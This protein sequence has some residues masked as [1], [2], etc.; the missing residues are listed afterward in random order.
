LV[1]AATATAGGVAAAG[2]ATAGAASRP[3]ER[4]IE[5]GRLVVARAF[6][7]ASNGHIQSIAHRG[8]TI[9]VL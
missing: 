3:I 2:T 8:R 5:A 6:M 7:S 9:L 4:T 1:L